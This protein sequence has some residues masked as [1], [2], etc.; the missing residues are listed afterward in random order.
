MGH[1]DMQE[2]MHAPQLNKASLKRGAEMTKLEPCARVT[3]FGLILRVKRHL[4]TYTHTQ[5]QMDIWPQ[6]I[7][8]GCLIHK[9]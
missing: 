4:H 6:N 2:S 8:R 7:S 5:R 1:A 9:S 3:C